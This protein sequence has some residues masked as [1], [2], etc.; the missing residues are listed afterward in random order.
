MTEHQLG[1]SGTQPARPW[2]IWVG[3]GALLVIAVALASIAIQ[4]STGIGPRADSVAGPNAAASG[5]PTPAEEPDEAN[6]AAERAARVIEHPVLNAGC[7]PV[8]DDEVIR[9]DDGKSVVLVSHGFGLVSCVLDALDAP[10]AV[11]ARMEQTRP[12]D[13]TLDAEWDFVRASWTFNGVDELRVVV[14]YMGP[15]QVEAD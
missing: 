8:L 9:S 14:E 1:D 6:E 13:G 4:L 12:L 15:D 11:Y 5:Q 3:L 10:D 7:T 2:W